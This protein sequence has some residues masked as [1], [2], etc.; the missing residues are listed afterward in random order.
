LRSTF[1]ITDYSQYIMNL[2]STNE[3]NSPQWSFEYSALA[4]Y[5][6]PDFSPQSWGDLAQSFNDDDKLFQLFYKH[7]YAS[8][9]SGTCEGLCKISI[10]CSVLNADPEATVM[11]V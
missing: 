2:T 10:I 3:L 8:A 9:N 6:L 4:S 11:C 5:N 7:Y 1:E